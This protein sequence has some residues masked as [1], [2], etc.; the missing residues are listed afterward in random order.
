MAVAAWLHLFNRSAADRLRAALLASPLKAIVRAMENKW[1]VDELYNALI[2]MP[3]KIKG[4]AL[5]MLDRYVLDILVVDGLG[6]L[7]KMIGR[8][9]SPLQNGS[10]SRMRH[11][12]LGSHLDRFADLGVAHAA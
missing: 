9:L 3:L 2:R 12:W 6:R 5:H 8:T 11:R 4:H 1:Y 10:C 7:P